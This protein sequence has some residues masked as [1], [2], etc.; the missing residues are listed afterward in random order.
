MAST[1]SILVTG[2]SS[3]I[4]AHCAKRLREDGWRVFVT[5]R[6]PEDI[7]RLKAEGFET[8][9]LDYR[10]PES[11]KICF[12]AVMK[13]ANGKLDALFNNGAYS[14]AG[15]VEDLPIEALREQFDANFFGWHELTL[16][17]APVMRK[18]GFGRI[19]Q[20]SS[21]LGL[22]AMPMRGAYNASKFAL[23]GLFLTMTMEL[24]GSGVHMSL[25]ETGPIPSKIA[26]NAVA[27]VEKYIDVK[28]SVHAESYEKRLAELRQG[29]TPDKKG[30]GQEPVY[31]QLKR[32]LNDKS[33]RPQYFVTKQT[34]IASMMKRV[35]PSKQL[36]KL[37]NAWS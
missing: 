19:V 12:D 25:I 6:K 27:Y 7:E 28:N 5:A 1:R 29:G 21:V 17:V 32:A 10:E 3:G 23:E 26:I 18:Q 22:V 37:L 8:F 13:A 11:I 4:G 24:K 30:K 36:Y 35:L 34:H 33:P 14:Q 9:Y 31:V 16:L 15:A 2:C 20:H